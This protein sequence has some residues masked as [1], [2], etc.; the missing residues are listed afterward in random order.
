MT[1]GKN[2]TLEIKS[3]VTGLLNA[4]IKYNLIIELFLQQYRISKSSIYRIKYPELK[5][6]NKR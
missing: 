2:L 4:N 5:A 1:K 6:N 3:F